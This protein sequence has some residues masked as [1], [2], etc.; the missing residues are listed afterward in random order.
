MTNF[1]LLGGVP[2]INAIGT[3]RTIGDTL[4][5][6]LKPRLQ[7]LTQYLREQLAKPTLRKVPMSF[8]P[9]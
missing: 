4:G 5:Q 9:I 6:R 3:P 8:Q 7:V 1:D 2:V